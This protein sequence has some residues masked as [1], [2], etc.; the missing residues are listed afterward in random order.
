MKIQTKGFFLAVVLALLPLSAQ[1][2]V[3]DINNSDIEGIKKIIVRSN[4]GCA[5]GYSTTFTCEHYLN[6]GEDVTLLDYV[7]GDCYYSYSY[8]SLTWLPSPAARSHITWNSTNF[9]NYG[10]SATP[11][12]VGRDAIATYVH[13]RFQIPIDPGVQKM[14]DTGCIGFLRI[15]ARRD[16]N[17]NTAHRYPGYGP[18]GRPET[19]TNPIYGTKTAY[20]SLAA[21]NNSAA[22]PSGFH[23]VIA[24]KYGKW[25]NGLPQ[26]GNNGEV[27]PGSMGDKDANDNFDYV[28]YMPDTQTWIGIN[29]DYPGISTQTMTEFSAVPMPALGSFDGPIF[30]KFC[31]PNG[32]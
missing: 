16:L 15:M 20:L 26:Q 28:V 9:P 21:L 7:S 24:A 13:N 17:N 11:V 25:K 2:D 18:T 1:A 30:I 14:L 31:V 29:H 19:E 5:S 6:F 8:E 12:G 10:F 22:C 32:T 23:T 3:T 27:D 4:I